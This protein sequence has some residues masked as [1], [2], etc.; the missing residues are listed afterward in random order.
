MAIGWFVESQSVLEPLFALV[1]DD[2]FVI[3]YN[4]KL[5]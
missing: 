2:E 5:T 1:K 3:Y 4:E